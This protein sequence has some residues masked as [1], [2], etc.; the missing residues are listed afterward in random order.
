MVNNL[1]VR[2]GYFLG[3]LGQSSIEYF[4]H[5]EVVTILIFTK[6]SHRKQYSVKVASQDIKGVNYNEEIVVVKVRLNFCL[7]KLS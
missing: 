3:T 1:K 4:Y 2:C 7:I 6:Y 5:L